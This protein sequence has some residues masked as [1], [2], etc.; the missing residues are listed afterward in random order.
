MMGVYIDISIYMLLHSVPLTLQQATIDLHLCWRLQ[1]TQG[2]SGW[3]SCG[4]TAPFSWVLVHTRFCLCPPR[5][6]FPC[7][8]WW[9]CGGVN[10]RTY[11]IPRSAASRAPALWQSTVDLYLCRR[12][13]DTVLAQSL[14]HLWVLV[15]TRFVWALWTSLAGKGFDS[16][17]DFAPPTILLGL[18]LCPWMWGIFFGKIQHS[19]INGSAASCS[20]RVLAEDERMSFY[21]TILHQYTELGYC[22][23]NTCSRCSLLRIWNKPH[24]WGLTQYF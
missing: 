1:D 13:S 5:V 15:G 20:F 3:V 6:C 2:K 12:H 16:K 10:K 22:L 17:C 24:L 7:K 18:L 14:W 8:F 4:V 23:P 9:L 19:P 21:S 11:A